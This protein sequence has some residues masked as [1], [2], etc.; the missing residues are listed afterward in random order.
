V[1]IWKES[2]YPGGPILGVGLTN[3]DGMF[4]FS[5]LDAPARYVIEATNVPGNPA[6]TSQTVELPAS[7]SAIAGLVV[8]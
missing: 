8:P 5:S 2:D 7:T 4:I 1:R 6:L 3:S